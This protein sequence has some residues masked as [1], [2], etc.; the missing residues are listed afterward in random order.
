MHHATKAIR[1]KGY[2]ALQS[3]RTC[4]FLRVKS[5]C[6]TSH[7]TCT[8]RQQGSRLKPL[9]TDSQLLSKREREMAT[10]ATKHAMLMI[11]KN[12]CNQNQTGFGPS[13]ALAYM[14]L[15]CMQP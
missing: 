11:W 7:H 12:A 1:R 15:R 2:P 5:L 10:P 8:I 9:R 14:L 3:L 6:G 13:M 4:P